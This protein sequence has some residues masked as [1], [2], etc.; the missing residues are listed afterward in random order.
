MWDDSTTYPYLIPMIWQGDGPNPSPGYSARGTMYG[1]G[2]IP[3]G[4]WGGNQDYVGGGTSTLPAYI[5]LYNSIS[6]ED[7]PAEMSLDLDTNDSGQLAFLLDVTLTADITTNNNKIVWVLTHDWEPGQSP[8]F[9]AS[10]ILY[11]QTPFPL[12]TSGETGSYEYGFDKPANWNLT[13]MKAIAII[14]T[15]DGDHKIHQAAI[16]D[17]SDW[18]LP[19]TLTS[20]N[21]V[22]SEDNIVLNWTTQSETDNLGFN[23]YRSENE[24]GFEDEEILQ[25]NADLIPGM[26]TIIQPTS[27]FFSDEYMALEG[28]TYF[29]WIE[30]VSTTNEL[31]LFGPTSVEISY[32]NEMITVLSEFNAVY[33]N[34]HSC[35]NWFTERET[36]NLGFFVQRSEDPNGY[37]LADCAQLNSDI[38][39]GMG[40]TSYETEYTFIDENLAIEG[41]TYWYW[42]ESMNPVGDINVFGPVSLEIPIQG[43][44]PNALLETALNSNYPNPFNP[45][46]TIS[47]SIEEGDCGRLTIFNLKGQIIVSE[48][49]NAGQHSYRW[50]GYGGGTGLYFYQLK[51][52]DSVITKK[53]LMMK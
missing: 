50:D 41:H 37:I 35:L 28:H 16:T 4:Q 33:K 47:F 22:F 8:D 27:Y 5:S 26:G 18:T 49:F 6:A 10:V 42:L 12:T 9:F 20:F 2:G 24:N 19:V 48:E 45:T 29:Y 40:T 14:Q 21:A 51:T 15:F 13:K 46:T 32:E 38:I 1:V 7:S 11:E 25:I 52:D 36:D 30:S 43:E 44:I 17:D 53:M 34:S 31:E 23:I 3:H 39:I